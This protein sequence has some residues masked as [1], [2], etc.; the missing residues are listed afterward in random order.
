MNHAG[1][2][3]LARRTGMPAW[4]FPQGGIQEGESPI[5]AM[6][7]E[8]DEELGLGENQ[9]K[10]LGQTRKWLKYKLPERFIRKLQMPLCLG[11]RQLWFLL[12]LVV[13]DENINLL[14]FSK[15]EFDTWRWVPYWEP[16]NE[17]IDFKRDVYQQALEELAIL[18]P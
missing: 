12:E 2:A 10:L 1:Q 7:R 11:Q 4:Q 14:S 3:L 13:A 17:V 15:P 8:L 16:I 5:D 6:Y 9:V 18:I